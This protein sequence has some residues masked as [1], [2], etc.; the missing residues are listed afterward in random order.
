MSKPVEQAAVELSLVAAAPYPY[1]LPSNKPCLVII[2]MQRDFV[3]PGGFGE[4]L[5]NDVSLLRV[6]IEP[7]QKLLATCRTLLA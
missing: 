2:D 1:P 4:S 3:E 7:L 5:G 6:V